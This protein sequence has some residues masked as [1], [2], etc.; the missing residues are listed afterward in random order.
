MAFRAT[1]T[2]PRPYSGV[3][4]QR[5]VL[6]TGL[7]LATACAKEDQ[8]AERSNS[9]RGD[10]IEPVQI[11]VA[12]RTTASRNIAVTGTVEP[13]LTVGVV[14]Q[15][16]GVLQDVAAREGDLVREGATLARVAI[17]EIEAQLRSA[18][19][20]L[21][22]ARAAAE[23][24]ASLFAVGVI[25]ASEQEL[26][27][28]SLAAAVAVREQLR[29]RESFAIIRAPITGVVLERRVEAGDLA[30]PQL[31][32][33]TLADISTLVVRVPVS[34]LNVTA[35][36]VGGATAVTLDALPGR[37]LTGTVRRIFPS[38]DSITRLVPV[39]VALSGDSARQAKPGFLARVTFRLSP[40]ED[41]LLIP[42]TAVLENPRG[43]VVY[44][45]QAGK[46]ARRSVERGA[47][48]EGRVE[49]T[50]GLTVGDSVVIAGN[51]LLRDGAVVRVMNPAT[52]TTAPA[53]SAGRTV[54]AQNVSAR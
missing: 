3:F 10:R 34:E 28:S 27:K 21:E 14:S 31:R 9:R 26:A 32:L 35:L 47:S 25:T 1:R 45:V 53:D 40:R 30:S 23:R 42:N 8:A 16:G 43:A 37:T 5:I 50:S 18:D 38:A 48:Y 2:N 12:E 54:G 49:I 24:A 36:R 44:V 41:V 52:P 4:S 13:L 15:I 17:P 11:A 6:T 22:V 46:A 19:V 39:E 20:S 51:T 29:V 33:F 7:L